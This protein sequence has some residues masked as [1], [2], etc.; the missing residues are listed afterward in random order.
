VGSLAPNEVVLWTWFGKIQ[1]VPVFDQFGSI[2]NS[3]YGGV[4]VEEQFPGTA[5]WFPI[6]QNMKADGTYADPV[7]ASENKGGGG[8]YVVLKGSPEANSWV[9]TD[10][11]RP[12][13]NSD[14][15]LDP[16]ACALGDTF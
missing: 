11:P 3:I 13:Y 1:N 6:N 12:C 7:F 9:T 14:S 4:P 5:V 2:L 8:L 16:S 15:P 10:P